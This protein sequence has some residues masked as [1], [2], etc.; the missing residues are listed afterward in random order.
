MG[1]KNSSFPSS[2]YSFGDVWSFSRL[3]YQF[4]VLLV[5]FIFFF[6][7]SFYSNCSAC[8]TRA[9]FSFFSYWAN[10]SAPNPET[11][12]DICLTFLTRHPHLIS[13]Y[14]TILNFDWWF[15]SH[16]QNE[17]ISITVWN[18]MTISFSFAELSQVLPRLTSSGEIFREQLSDLFCLWCRDVVFT[19]IFLPFSMAAP[20]LFLFTFFYD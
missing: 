16:F 4:F 2:L 5:T 19:W 3:S 15:L 18:P 14:S 13:W 7:C 20:S 11:H 8:C 1:R 9:K 12:T 6:L 17:Q 10:P